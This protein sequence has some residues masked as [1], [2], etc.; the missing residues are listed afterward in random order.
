MS[1]VEPDF[2]RMAMLL[3]IVQK[4]HTVTPQHTYLSS[5][6]ANELKEMN[7]AIAKEARER[8]ITAPEERITAADMEENPALVQ[9]PEVTKTHYEGEIV[10]H[11]EESEP[12]IRRN[13]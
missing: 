8:K 13:L 4:V 11:T 7:D 2:E 3:D 12:A 1:K 6:A 9:E 10:D 5:A